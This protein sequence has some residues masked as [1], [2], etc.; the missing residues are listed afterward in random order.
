MPLLALMVLWGTGGRTVAIGGASQVG[1]ATAQVGATGATDPLNQPMAG[2]VAPGL[3]GKVCNVADAIYAGGAV[4]TVDP[5][6]AIDATAAILAAIH[7]CTAT[8]NNVIEL[9]RGSGVLG[10]PA[11]Y[12]VN[13]YLPLQVA[14]PNTH[15]SYPVTFAGQGR[16][17]VTLRQLNSTSA[18]LGM[19][20]SYDIVRSITLDTATANASQGIGTSQDYTQALW[21]R[22]LHGNR[23]SRFSLY[24]AGNL[25]PR[26]YSLGN[27]VDQLD[28]VDT[29]CDDSF[30]WA[31]NNQGSI[32][33]VT[34]KGSRLAVYKDSYLTVTNYAYTP[35]TQ[36]C[37]SSLNGFYVSAP[38]DHITILNYSSS[39][40]GGKT[41]SNATAPNGISDLTIRGYNLTGTND[42]LA[43]GNVADATISDYN[44]G[45]VYIPCNFGQNKLRV[46]P[47]IIGDGVTLHNNV[48][49]T[50]CSLPGVAFIQQPGIPVTLTMNNATLEHSA[51]GGATFSNYYGSKGAQATAAI[52][53]GYWLNSP[54][55]LKKN[56]TGITWQ[57]FGLTPCPLVA[58]L[59]C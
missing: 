15:S 51:V 27:V 2:M 39:G 30:V 31:S 24:Y 18:L 16:D 55:W 22:V 54:Y 49:V 35:G 23:A 12:S 26:G 37:L 4:A 41:S 9:P 5:A 33:N 29:M 56:N 43:I 40:E 32:S 44:V 34:H 36:T 17:Y 52:T 20:A 6:P 3:G 50:N 42:A 8:P 53:G 1:T 7:D 58:P 13:A 38:S 28:L 11:V 19:R 57:I 47:G 10:H 48:T 46:L 59:Y 21:L 45:G 14:L 25:N